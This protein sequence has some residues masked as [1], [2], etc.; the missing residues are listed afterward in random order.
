MRRAWIVLFMIALLPLRG[1]AVVSMAPVPTPV[2]APATGVHA[3]VVAPREQAT[4]PPCHGAP[5]SAATHADAAPSTT[6][7][8]DID[9]TMPTHLCLACDLCHTPLATPAL[10]NLLPPAPP[11]A[12]PGASSERDTGRH[13]AGTLERP[14]RG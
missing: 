3:Q 8:A 4:L 10:P 9:G 13:L 7:G 1:W 12:A 14:P 2:A 11:A 5:A 6:H